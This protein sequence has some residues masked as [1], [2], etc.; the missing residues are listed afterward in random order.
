M[1]MGTIHTTL[2]YTKDPRVARRYFRNR[3]IKGAKILMVT[4]TKGGSMVH[5]L[6]TKPKRRTGFGVRRFPTW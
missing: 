4:K 6:K 3:K 1:R 2:E 5:F